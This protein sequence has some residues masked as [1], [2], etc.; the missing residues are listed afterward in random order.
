MVALGI[1]RWRAYFRSG[2]IVDLPFVL[3]WLR[4]MS[5]SRSSA[6]YLIHGFQLIVHRFVQLAILH[7]RDAV[8]RGLRV[9][10]GRDRRSMALVPRTESLLFGRTL[11]GKSVWTV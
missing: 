6:P 5:S 10:T 8:R 3:E 11:P 9:D 2:S 4:E 7:H 1:Y